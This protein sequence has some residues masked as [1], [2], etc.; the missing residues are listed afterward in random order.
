MRYS[1]KHIIKESIPVLIISI[2]ITI[3]AGI[4]LNSSEHLLT[5]IPGII[6]MVPAFINMSGSL[7]SV[8]ASRLSSAL[9]MGTIHPKLHRT[10]TL[11]RNIIAMVIISLVSFLFL[12]LVGGVLMSLFGLA[13]ANIL[14]IAFMIF[15]AG[16]I[17][18]LLLMSFTIIMS[19]YLFKKGDDPDNW[20]IPILTS[21]SDLIGIILLLTFVSLAI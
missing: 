3:C 20:V 14:L 5:A 16:I 15:I 19:Y 10:K 13:N 12:G 1:F 11:D 18:S 9:H 8:L 2:L 21:G 6:I 4:I 17:T 7:M